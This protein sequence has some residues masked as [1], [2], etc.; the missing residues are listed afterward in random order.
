MAGYVFGTASE[1]AVRSDAAIMV[2]ETD[3]G[4]VLF[5]IPWEHVVLVGTTD[6]PIEEIELEP[7]PF[8]EEVLLAA[9]REALDHDEEARKRHEDVRHLEVRLKGLTPRQ[10][11]VMELMVRGFT[12]KKIAADLGISGR[13]VELH[14]ARV[15]R[16]LEVGSAA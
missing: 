2:P 10:R 11:E 7:K 16:S 3:D 14:R 1:D 8:R 15:F 4:R 6:T 9:V 12:N 5:A 13:T